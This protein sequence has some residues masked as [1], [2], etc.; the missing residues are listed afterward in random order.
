MQSRRFE[1][2]LHRGGGDVR[3]DG[4]RMRP[5]APAP[6]GF[7]SDEDGVGGHKSRE[8]VSS[9]PGPRAPSA[10]PARDEGEG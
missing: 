5:P 8:E 4:D 9:L 10:G 3:K 2:E 7:E 1:I 6:T